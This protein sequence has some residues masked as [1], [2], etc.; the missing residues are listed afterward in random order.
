MQITTEIL[1]HL[2]FLVWKDILKI[3][4]ADKNIPYAHYLIAI[5]YYEQI[6]DEKKD[7]KPL[8]RAKKKFE[9]IIQ[10]YPDTDYAIDAKI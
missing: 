9:F 10:T 1:I 6:L 5:C 3:I 2:Q 4:Q 8:L 7:L